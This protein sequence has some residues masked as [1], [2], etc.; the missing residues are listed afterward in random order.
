[1]RD[2]NQR[3][4]NI[5]DVAYRWG[6]NYLSHFNKAFRSRFDLTPGEWRHTADAC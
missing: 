2:P 4:L 6:F 5:S 1:L 3:A